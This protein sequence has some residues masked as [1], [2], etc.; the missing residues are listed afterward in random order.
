M[1]IRSLLYPHLADLL[2]NIRIDSRI[3]ERWNL[4]GVYVVAGQHHVGPDWHLANAKS[5]KNLNKSL[6]FVRIPNYRGSQG[7]TINMTPMIDVTFLLIIFFLVSSQW[8]RRRVSSGK[9]THRIADRLASLAD[10]RFR[11][12]R[13]WSRLDEL[14]GGDSSVRLVSH[15]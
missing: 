14:G 9:V 4:A 8:V 7:V 12:L 13:G 1:D 3:F 10:F 5:R 2:P 11:V 15:F 6:S